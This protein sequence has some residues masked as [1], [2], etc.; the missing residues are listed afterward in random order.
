MPTFTEDI[1]LAPESEIVCYCSAVTKREI[2][3]AIASGADSLTA[4]K[5]VTGACTVAR[6][7]E[8]NPRGR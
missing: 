4:I 8:M 7:K 6:C 2:V 1:L 5:D 3:E